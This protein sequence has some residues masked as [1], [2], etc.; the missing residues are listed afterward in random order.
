MIMRIEYTAYLHYL[1]ER[2]NKKNINWDAPVFEIYLEW[3]YSKRGATEPVDFEVESV[4]KNFTRKATRYALLKARGKQIL[5]KLEKVDETG[6]D[7]K[8]VFQEKRAICDDEYDSLLKEHHDHNNHLGFIKCYYEV[9]L[10][11]LLFAMWFVFFLCG[12]WH[13]IK[14]FQNTIIYFFI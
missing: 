2:E 8:A 12:W 11:H 3:Q 7:G 13:F 5:C 6:K 10:H 1:V 4:R 14:T 9:G